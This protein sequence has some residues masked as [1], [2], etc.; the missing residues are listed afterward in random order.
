MIYPTASDVSRCVEHTLSTLMDDKLP[1]MAVKSALATSGLLVRHVELRVRLERSLLLDDVDKA[2]ALLNVIAAYLSGGS[3]DRIKLGKDIGTSLT[4]AP[5]LLTAAPEDTE[6]IRERAKELRELIYVSLKE[7]Q[8]AIAAEKAAK[9]YQEIRRQIR[10]YITY[11]IE[12]E[13]KLIT[14]AFFGHGPRR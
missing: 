5:Q 1:R 6:T 10:E 13:G 12:Q 2:S 11:Q 8:S 4:N 7:L 3:T 14:P 9:E